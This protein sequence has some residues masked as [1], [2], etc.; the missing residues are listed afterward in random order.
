MGLFK[1]I[2]QSSVLTERRINWNENSKKGDAGLV[3]ELLSGSRKK[4]K[5][6]GELHLFRSF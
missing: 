6:E 3:D 2:C 1:I 5:T 4:G